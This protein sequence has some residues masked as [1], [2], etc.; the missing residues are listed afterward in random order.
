MKLVRYLENGQINQY[1]SLFGTYKGSF[2]LYYIHW[3]PVNQTTG[4][5]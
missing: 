5:M 2:I 3:M 1:W 4:N